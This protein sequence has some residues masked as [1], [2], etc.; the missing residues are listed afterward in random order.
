MT[1]PIP[2]SLIIA[3]VF[4]KSEAK[5]LS[6]LLMN[7][8]L[9]SFARTSLMVQWVENCLQCRRP[10]LGSWIGKI[11]WRRDKLPTPV[12]V[13]FP[14]GSAGKESVCNVGDLGLIPGWED[15]LEKGKATHSS[16]LAWRIPWSV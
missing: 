14:C 9:Q 12:F 4:R 7:K 15:P 3:K 5:Y 1:V 13:G 11:R 2:G 16:I 10:Q 8:I 6:A